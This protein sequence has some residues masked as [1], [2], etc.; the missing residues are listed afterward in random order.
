MKMEIYL[1]TICSLMA[2]ASLVSL[3]VPRFR[4]RS[5]WPGSGAPRSPISLGLFS[6]LTAQGAF[7][8]FGVFDGRRIYTSIPVITAVLLA[9]FAGVDIYFADKSKKK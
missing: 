2:L 6:L 8:M 7:L 9:V 5:R 1:G 4:K 3:I